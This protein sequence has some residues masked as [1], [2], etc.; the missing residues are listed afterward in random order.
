MRPHPVY[1]L[2][3]TLLNFLNKHVHLPVLELFIINFRDTR[4]N[5]SKLTKLN[6]WEYRLAW[7]NISSKG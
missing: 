2:T 4:N 3:F 6:V 1:F 7:F 5:S